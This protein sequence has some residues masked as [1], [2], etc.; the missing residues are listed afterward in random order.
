MFPFYLR[1]VGIQ[2]MMKQSVVKALTSGGMGGCASSAP[3]PAPPI[4]IASSILEMDIKTLEQVCSD[5]IDKISR[6]LEQK[7]AEDK[8]DKN[9]KRKRD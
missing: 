5:V 6:K 7:E 8:D 1:S 2:I 4:D 3:A 9:G